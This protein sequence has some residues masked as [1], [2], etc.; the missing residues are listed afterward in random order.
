MPNGGTVTARIIE[1]I[2][3]VAAMDWDECAGSGNPFITHAF[4]V[5]LECSGSVGA[6]AGWL[7]QHLLIENNEALTNIDGLASLTSIG[8]DLVIAENDALADVDGLGSL[9]SVGE[10]LEIGDGLDG[11]NTALTHLDGLAA[12]TSVGGALFIGGNSALASAGGMPML[13][14]SRTTRSMIC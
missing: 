8:G 7:P 1:R 9:V 2:T 3:E 12:L 6:K 11:N 10:D 4:L 5:A 14:A 13:Y